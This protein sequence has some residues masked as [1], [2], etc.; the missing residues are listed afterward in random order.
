MLIILI[1]LRTLI[2][3]LFLLSN[4]GFSA[5][6]RVPV[7]APLREVVA[8]TATS[9]LARRAATHATA[10]GKV[11][12]TVTFATLPTSATMRVAPALYNKARVLTFE[13]DDSPVSTFT[14]LLPLL[15]G[16]VASGGQQCPGLRFSDG[17][18]NL[19]PWTAA[20]AING[21]HLY[22]GVYSVLLDPGPN[23][24]V[25]MLMWT[26]AQEL[27]DSGWDIEN[28]SDLHS[29]RLEDP[30]PAQQLADLDQLIGDRLKGYKP[31]VH[32]VPADHAGYPTAA[33]AAG[34][35]AV[36]SA[37][38]R[39]GL[40]RVNLWNA[41]RVKMTDLPDPGTR[42]VY[43]RENAD[44]NKGAGETSD[45]HLVRLKKLSD[46]LMAA[47]STPSDVYMQRVFTHGMNFATLAD[48]LTYTQE[49]AQDR[50]WVTSLREFG[51]YRRLSREVLKSETLRGNTLT[52][53][54]DYANISPNTRFQN[55]TLLVD[56]PA[57][58]ASITVSGANSAT[59]NLATKQV[60]V[61][62]AQAAPTPLPVQLTAFT[63]RREGAD[64][65]LAWR[66]ASEQRAGRFQV[67]RSADG[68]SFAAVGTVAAAGT[69]STPR[70]YAF[71]DAAAPA[72][73]GWYYRLLQLD[74]DGARSYS[75]VAL[76]AATT[77]AAPEE[78]R[79]GVTPNPAQVNDR[80]S[81]T[82]QGCAGQRLEVQ[83][84]DALG[85][86]AFTQSARPTASPQA[87]PLA[88]PASVGAGVYTLRVTGGS[89]PLQ[90][91]V[92]L[93]R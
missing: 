4:S 82:V 77:G 72:G 55:L 33:F 14:D 80:L 59:Y 10:G 73:S 32:I 15:R 54:L 19:R 35:L 75:P 34:Y 66:T 7:P 27:L 50:L 2:L 44:L 46:N 1:R 62:G 88:L 90:T 13:Q 23:R 21:H 67:Q 63:A 58:I 56:S 93:T 76:V 81:V 49:I 64:V 18:G 86:V 60:N 16:G 91:R 24:N 43:N 87:L 53:D 78:A 3:S 37:S 25:N 6:G 40:P 52:V 65:Q 12:I 30:T 68:R 51:E 45:T 29:N 41:N 8:S 22:Q 61:F 47:G 28:H 9:P 17:C 11:R 5:H 20:V 36:S 42:F 83:L 84:L 39:D 71:L 85:R 70:S 89:R 57:D 79:A 92:L 74:T 38:V 69:T 31:S 26:Q 48:W